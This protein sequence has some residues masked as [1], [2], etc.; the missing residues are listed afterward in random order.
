M[1]NDI[2]S[3][4]LPGFGRAGQILIP[5]VRALSELTNSIPSKV[6]SYLKTQL[7]D[8]SYLTYIKEVLLGDR[9][10]VPRRPILIIEPI[11][12][13]EEEFSYQ[14]QDLYMTISIFGV[15][16]VPAKGS[17][18]T[19][20][21]KYR[22]LLDIENHVKLAIDEDRT[23]GLDGVIHTK[24]LNTAYDYTAYPTRVFDLQIEVHFRQTK[25]TRS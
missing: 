16:D 10:N 13:R 21:S 18:L 4:L 1:S 19:G 6:L 2:N 25:G 7:E 8:S 9:L 22:G 15:Q 24:A 3:L 17:Q 14:R 5:G 12:L 23:L 11:G 20:N